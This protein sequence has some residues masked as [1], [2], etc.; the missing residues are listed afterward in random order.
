MDD[1]CESDDDE[2]N[3]FL[4]LGVYTADS[5]VDGTVD[6][7]DENQDVLA[8]LFSSST[9]L[10]T[11]VQAVK[12][13]RQW[14]IPEF[15]QQ[16][17]GD[18]CFEISINDETVFVH[19]EHRR[20]STGSDIWDSALVLSHALSRLQTLTN[21]TVVELGSGTGA[22]GLVCAKCLHANRVILTDLPA[23]LELIE[24]NRAANSLTLTAV[25]LFALDWEDET[26]V[27]RLM[28]TERAP[29]D[30]VIGSDLF[31]PFAKHLLQPLARTIRDL[32]LSGST[33]AEAWICYEER[34]DPSDFFRFAADFG[35]AVSEVHHSLLHATFQDASIHLLHMF[36][37]S[38]H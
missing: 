14:G 20:Y 17:N 13:R 4:S 9:D 27:H 15:E 2:I 35:L 19:L 6:R 12:R 33:H 10:S 25:S 24:R 36:V 31:L 23:N 5:V 37:K 30:V 21:K 22:V 3:P 28:E 34:F 8:T 38:N 1:E 29:L 11:P 7:N 26:A 18:C 32:L 16:C